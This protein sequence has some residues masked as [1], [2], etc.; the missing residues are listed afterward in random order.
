MT[1]GATIKQLRQEQDITQEQL[2]DALGITSRAVSQ[3]ETDTTA[4]DISQLPALANFFDVT[5]DH[6]LGV[7]TARKEEEVGK[8]LDQV[9]KYGNEGRDDKIIEYLSEKIKKYPKE[10]ILLNYLA[11][12][13]DEHYFNH[14]NADD[15]KLKKEKSEQIISLCERAL[16]YYKPTEDNSF[17]KQTLVYHYQEIG[18]LDKA[19]EIAESLPI[20]AC[21]RDMLYSITLKDDKEALLANQSSLLWSFLQ[22]MHRVFIRIYESSQYTIEQKIEILDADDALIRLITGEEPN[23][24]NEKLKDNAASRAGCLLHL[25][26]NE[27][28]L[29]MLEKAYDYA[30]KFENRPDIMHYT[31]CWLS[32]IVGT[33]EE[34]FKTVTDTNYDELYVFITKPQNKFCEVFKGNDRFEL[35]MEKLKEKISK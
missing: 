5:T 27:K 20:I 22:M 2:A 15:E 11:F 33:R 24:Y 14:K 9:N 13:L 32:E 19:R 18:E 30:D 21:T 16:K 28:A 26:E 8:I 12:A 3:W 4:P 31:P 7:D 10:P 23:F 35:L 34:H 25:G 6:L 1:I 29:D 17:A